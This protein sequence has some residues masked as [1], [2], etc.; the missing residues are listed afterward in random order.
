[1]HVSALP[2]RWLYMLLRFVLVGFLSGL[3]GLGIGAG[4]SRFTELD[5]QSGYT[6]AL[7]Q[8]DSRLPPGLESIET[9]HGGHDHAPKAAPAEAP[10]HEKNVAA[11]RYRWSSDTTLEFIKYRAV[12][13][14]KA[15][16]INDSPGGH[17]HGTIDEWFIIQRIGYEI[18]ADLGVGV[19]QN[20]RRLRDRNVTDPLNQGVEQ[21]AQGFG[22]IVLD[23]KYRFMR[24]GDTFPVDL[25]VYANIKAP[26][27][28]NDERDPFGVLF[29][30][31]DQPGSGSWDGGMGIVA[32]RRWG[33][34]SASGSFGF[35]IRG[36]GDREFKSGDSV[37]L[38][39][40][41]GRQLL[42]E[43]WGWKMDA[44]L[45]VSG[46]YEYEG[47]D[48]GEVDRNHGGKFVVVEPSIAVHPINRLTLTVSAPLPVY[49]EFNG[50]H[51]KQAYG[52]QFNIGVRF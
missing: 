26:T 27:G 21:K 41:A 52:I 39:L 8:K 24:Q 28:E 40:S 11:L 19:S 36:E 37:R 50:T 35:S 22:D 15:F 46:I 29:D 14:E 44:N 1:M 16:E 32:S 42:P 3:T 49:Q 51:Q 25:S 13:V 17:L 30:T 45:G 9:K 12:N 33:R 10:A 5:P 6:L 48:M 18:S 4:E 31:H 43:C 47:R 38:T 23:I 34:W 7:W 20:F 2:K